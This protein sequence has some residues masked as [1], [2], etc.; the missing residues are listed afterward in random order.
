M[1]IEDAKKKTNTKNKKTFN[2][3]CWRLKINLYFRFQY[4]EILEQK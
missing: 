3:L 2:Y 4:S 1:F